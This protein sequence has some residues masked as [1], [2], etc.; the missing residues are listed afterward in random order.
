M[1]APGSP[2]LGRAF[3][4]AVV[5]LADVVL[6]TTPFHTRWTPN[7]VSHQ[8]PRP[9]GRSSGAFS[10]PHFEMSPDRNTFCRFQPCATRAS[11]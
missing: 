7:L 5:E 4:S 11:M 3:D 6:S 10:P 1:A 2:G 8:S 9:A